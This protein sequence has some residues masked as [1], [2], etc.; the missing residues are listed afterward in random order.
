M[1][2]AYGKSVTPNESTRLARGNHGL[3]FATAGPHTHSLLT[4]VYE[5]SR[6]L[7][8]VCDGVIALG[9]DIQRRAPQTIQV[10]YTLDGCMARRPRSVR[11]GGLIGLRRAKPL[12]WF[13]FST[14]SEV[15]KDE[16]WEDSQYLVHRRAICRVPALSD[17]E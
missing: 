10:Y 8:L 17:I 1:G 12:T 7:A 16:I 14:L 13:S 4:R 2:C 6:T 9:Q 3:R 5:F 11:E 15:Y